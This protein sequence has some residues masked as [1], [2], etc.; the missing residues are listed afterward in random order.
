MN[1]MFR[2]LW[3]LLRL[4]LKP[5]A[6]TL[7]EPFRRPFRVW[8][9]DCDFN[10]HLTNSR[11][12]ALIDLARIE[13]LA[14]LKVLGPLLKKRWQPMLS[15]TE[16]TFIR[17][18]PPLCRFDLVTRILAWDEKYFYFEQRFETP[19]TVHAVCLGRAAFVQGRELV[20]PARIV[21]L[22][23]HSG[24]APACPPVID[25]WRLLLNEKKNHFVAQS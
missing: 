1:L 8:P 7:T 16:I 13:Q 21:A 24:E 25:A 10:L 9:T 20:S 18:L 11:Y 5:Q 22:A 19:G 23:G 12:F 3:M 2:L 14:R 4:V 15:A 17:P 6:L